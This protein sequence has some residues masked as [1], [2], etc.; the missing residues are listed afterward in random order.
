MI[1]MELKVIRHNPNWLTS[2]LTVVPY[3][4]FSRKKSKINLLNIRVLWGISVS[5][6]IAVV[7]V[8]K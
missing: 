2:L 6:I 8:G 4:F 1:D 5:E 7:E 3:D